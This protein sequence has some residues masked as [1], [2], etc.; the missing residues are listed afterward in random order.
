MMNAQPE[1][2]RPF[3]SFFD[4]QRAAVIRDTTAVRLRKAAQG[5]KTRSFFFHSNYLPFRG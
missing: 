4:L 3:H 2:G 5:L 1:K